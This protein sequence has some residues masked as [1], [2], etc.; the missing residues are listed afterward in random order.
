VDAS[1]YAPITAENTSLASKEEKA[2]LGGRVVIVQ[3]LL[4]VD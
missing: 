1:V 4:E 3:Q 2:K